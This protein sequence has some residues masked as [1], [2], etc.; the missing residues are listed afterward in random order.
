MVVAL[1]V[2]LPYAVALKIVPLR[3]ILSLPICAAALGYLGGLAFPA[4][5]FMAVAA[6]FFLFDETF[7]I[8]GGN[9]PT[10][11]AREV[12]FSICPSFCT[13]YFPVPP[14]RPPT[15]Q[16]PPTRS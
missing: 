8:Y 12:S 11:L 4:P 1:D 3:A 14:Y 13:L 10:A 16:E 9:N 6:T 5:A 15:R 7:T 2:A